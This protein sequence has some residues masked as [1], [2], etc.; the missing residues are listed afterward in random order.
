MTPDMMSLDH[1]RFVAFGSQVLAALAVLVGF[2]IAA[3]IVRG[4]VLHVAERDRERGDVL[5]LLA[6]AARV[7]V[8]G[9]GAVSALGTL[10][11]DVT[12]LIAGLGLTGFALGFA[13]KDSLS[14]AIAGLMIMLNRPFRSGDRVAVGGFEGT[15]AAIDLRYVHLVEGEKRF[16]VPNA[17][18][19]TSPVT[20][21]RPPPA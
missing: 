5:R 19:M 4:V 15:V 2:W 11:V 17:T 14:S 20:V 7:A 16:L 21:T 1:A 8:L 10:G 13:L 18:V 12:A 6:G 9:F 3:S